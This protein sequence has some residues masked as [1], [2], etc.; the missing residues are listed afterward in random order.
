MIVK[1]RRA[2]RSRPL[3]RWFGG[4]FQQRRWVISHF[5]PH[6]LYV[7]PLGGGGS[8]LLDKAPS[9]A[10]IYN[11][12]D[13]E[14]VHLF[15]VLRDE[16]LAPRLIRAVELTPYSRQEFYDAYLETSHPVERA[17]RMIVRAFMGYGTDGALG[18]YKTG[19][20]GKA[21]RGEAVP[22]QEWANYPIQLRTIC[23]RIQSGVTIENIDAWEL[24]QRE[25]GEGVLFYLD[26]P[27]PPD[28]RSRGARRR[29][30]G[31]H[32]YNHEMTTE[33]HEVLL[34][35][36]KGLKSMVVL[37]SYPNQLYDIAL[38]GWR[39]SEHAAFADGGRP[40][41][42]AIYINEAAAAALD[43]HRDGHGPLFP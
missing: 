30:A 5:P 20:R 15:R 17:R 13:G 3:I 24:M 8:V 41:T 19:F 25:D 29:G 1:K 39:R 32:V 14:I 2:A 23:A 11:D 12:L 36:V 26:P 16:M 35:R 6:S 31:Y 18:T 22:A 7:E 37:S 27:Y 4:K 34:E 38:E 42:E 33:D 21:R 9:T 43:R 28:V 10:E 40:R